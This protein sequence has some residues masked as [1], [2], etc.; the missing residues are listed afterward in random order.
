MPTINVSTDIGKAI[1]ALATYS[2]ARNFNF[3]VARALTLT[4]KEIQTEVRNNLPSRFTLRRESFIKQGIQIKPATKES[5]EALVFSRDDFM[6]LQETGGQKNPLGNYLAIP[7]SLVRRT[8][9]DV[10]RKADRP[11]SLGDK[12]GIVEVKGNLY[13]ALKK[14]RRTANGQQLRLLYLLIPKATLKERLGLARDA[15]RVARERFGP[16]LREALAQA[17]RPR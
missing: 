8:P 17:V 6:G 5:L 7:T 2:E 1:A 9:K 10:I 13:L 11:K 3:A 4:A 16:L 15:K 14:P 12:A